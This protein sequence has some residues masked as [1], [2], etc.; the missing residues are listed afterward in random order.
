[1]EKYDIYIKKFKIALAIL[2]ASIVAFI[3]LIV[4][5]IPS[6]QKV[7][8]I[9][10]S[11]TQ[12]ASTLADAERRLNDLKNSIKKEEQE[13]NNLIR[14]IFKPV[15]EGLTTENA[16]ADEFGEIL[17]IMRENKIKAR[18]IKYEYDP[19]DDNF[20]KNVP[21]KYFVCRVSMDIIASYVQIENF[22]RDLFKHEHF[23]EISKL[24]ITPYQKNKRILLANMQ[25]KLYAL[26]DPSSPPPPKP[27]DQAKPADQQP[28]EQPAEQQQ[29]E[30]PGNIEQQ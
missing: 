14:S 18:T 1:M 2:V 24:E 7:S 9:E 4:K 8:E 29:A 20:V 15:N 22:I 5:T 11:Y 3:F 23:L 16:I 12:Q 25:I 10:K 26:R 6:I 17:Q 28:A 21:E 19:Q 13:D 27:A 30:G